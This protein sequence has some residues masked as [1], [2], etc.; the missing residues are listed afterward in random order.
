M[1]LNVRFTPLTILVVVMTVLSTFSLLFY[2]YNERQA[3]E[4]QRQTNT[5]FLQTLK[6]RGELFEDD[7]DALYTLF[8]ASIK[9]QGDPKK[10]KKALATWQHRRHV[11]DK[12]LKQYQYPDLEDTCQS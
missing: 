8:D 5:V 7:R 10:M 9:N 1:S 11:L 6:D 4:C 12:R 3:A 2:I